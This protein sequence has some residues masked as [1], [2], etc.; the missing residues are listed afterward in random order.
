[1]PDIR[2]VCLS[3]MHLGAETSLLT[4]LKVGQSEIDPSEASPVFKKLVECLQYL[5]SQNEDKDQKPI[6]VLNGDILELSL[7]Q[8]QNAAMAFERFIDLITD[9]G[10]E[11]F[12]RIIY[13]PGNHDHH[14]WESARETQYVEYISTKPWGTPLPFPWHAT[15]IFTNPVPSYFLTRLVKKHPQLKAKDMFIHMAYPN[16]GLFSDDKTKCVIFHHG[17]FIESIYMLMSTLK[18]MVFPGSQIPKHIWDIEIE[19]FAWID[20]FWSMMGRSGEV[21]KDIGIIYEKMQDKQQLKKLLYNLADGLAKKYDVPG[22]GKKMKAAILKALFWYLANKLVVPERARPERLLGKE[23]INGLKSYVN[24]PLKE[25]FMMDPKSKGKPSKVTFVF[26]HTHKPF[27]EKRDSDEYPDGFNV[28]NS[29]GWVV[30]KVDRQLLHG[31]AV[32]LIDENLEA[33]SLRMYNETKHPDKYTVSVQE[34]R[35]P[36][37]QPSVFHARI[38]GLVKGSYQLWESFS[39]A[40]AQ[41]VKVRAQNLRARIQHADNSSGS[42][43]YFTDKNGKNLSSL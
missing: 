5:I 4:N 14:L 15:N 29:G 31:G 18:T 28:Y 24:G 9:Q 22:W 40:V 12:D 33:T 35:H 6:L 37:D 21:G 20:F 23:T 3:D 19:N 17:H 25:Q 38:D 10:K 41:A 36:V 34:A 32:I 11:L 42:I 16:F 26:G 2:Y 43:F 13:N 7:A 30:D 39:N 27:Q 1:M 8:D